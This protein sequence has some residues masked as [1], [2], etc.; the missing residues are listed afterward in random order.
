MGASGADQ[1]GDQLPTR[2]RRLL[3][4]LMIWTLLVKT[5]DGW[6]AGPVRPWRA[7]AIGAGSA[8]ATRSV[9]DATAASGCCAEGL[10][11]CAQ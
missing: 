6:A 2:R 1:L 3:P 4:L 5:C 8:H 10:H 7:E 11:R 9:C